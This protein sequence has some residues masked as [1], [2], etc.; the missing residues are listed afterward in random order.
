MRLAVYQNKV[1]IRILALHLEYRL[2]KQESRAD[3]RLC[4]ALDR[5]L[6]RLDKSIRGRLS[7]LVI[8]GADA[9]LLRVLLNSLPGTLVE[10]LV[11]NCTDVN[12]KR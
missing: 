8:F 1:H 3:N 10:R 9:I 7:G 4:A 5:E 2:L 11:I 6:D 12:H